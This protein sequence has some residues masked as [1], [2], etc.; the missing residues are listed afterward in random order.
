MNLDGHSII[1]EVFF[2][3]WH[4][5]DEYINIWLGGTLGSNYV[6]LICNGILYIAHPHR[7]C[8]FELCCAQF[9]CCIIMFLLKLLYLISF[10]IFFCLIIQ[11]STSSCQGCKPQHS[12]V[13]TQKFCSALCTKKWNFE[14]FFSSFLQV[15]LRLWKTIS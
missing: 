7:G 5:R 8:V 3:L 2:F 10:P 9:S 12:P 1:L 14:C 4:S 13:N 6:H 11:N 15:S